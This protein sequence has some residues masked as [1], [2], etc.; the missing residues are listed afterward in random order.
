MEDISVHVLCNGVFHP[1]VWN[2]ISLIKC[3]WDPKLKRVLFL[4]VWFFLQILCP[5]THL[6]LTVILRLLRESS[7]Q[8][9]W[10]VPVE[11]DAFPA[12]SPFWGQLPL[13]CGSSCSLSH[14]HPGSSLWNRVCRRARLSLSLILSNL[15]LDVNFISLIFLIYTFN[16]FYHPCRSSG[17]FSFLIQWFLAL[18]L[19]CRAA[20]LP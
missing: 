15:L 13:V 10:A 17:F 20:S 3:I 4:L 6:L 19:P 8:E 18:L 9:G 12:H 16:A 5:A 1:S 11:A 2:R 14:S 7:A